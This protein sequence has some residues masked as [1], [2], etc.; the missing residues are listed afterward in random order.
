MATACSLSVAGA[1]PDI[2][3]VVTWNIKSNQTP[4]R[5]RQEMAFLATLT[6][7]VIVLNEASSSN[8]DIY[9][10]ELNAQTHQAWSVVFQRHCA[11]I[12]W[13]SA[14]SSCDALEEE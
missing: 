3:D 2:V 12:R 1:A 9:T 14:A 10:Q 5:A 8:L 13:N 7:Q 6:P 4:A 11:P